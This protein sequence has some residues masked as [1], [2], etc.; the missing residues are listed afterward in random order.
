MNSIYL[1]SLILGESISIGGNG[2][3][4]SAFL[5]GENGYRKKVAAKKISNLESASKIIEEAKLQATLNHPN[6]CSVIDIRSVDSITYLIMEFLD[7]ITLKALINEK[8]QNSKTFDPEFIEKLI[9]EISSALDYAHQNR[10][11]HRD[12]TPSNIIVTK[13]NL[14]K[15][16]DFGLAS[17]ID[18]NNT[19]Y[20]KTLNGTFD[21][22]SPERIDGLKGIKDSDYFALGAIAFELVTLK[23][24]FSGDSDYKVLNSIKEK[25]IIKPLNLRSEF[26][27]IFD[28]II[29]LLEKEPS[30]RFKHKEVIEIL[31]LKKNVK[32]TKR[33]I[34]AFALLFLFVLILSQ[35]LPLIRKHSNKKVFVI[36]SNESQL[37]VAKQNVIQEK[38]NIDQCFI[39]F[40]HSI[41][42]FD[43]LYNASTRDNFFQQIH[44]GNFKNSINDILNQIEQSRDNYSQLFMACSD[45]DKNGNTQKVFNLLANHLMYV[46]ENG[47]KILDLNSGNFSDE[48]VSAAVGNALKIPYAGIVEKIELN[49][50]IYGEF[51]EGKIDFNTKNFIKIGLPSIPNHL[52]AE[53]CRDI[54]SNL[55]LAQYASGWFPSLNLKSNA[56]FI[57]YNVN[58]I[59]IEK[60]ME[61]E[62]YFSRTADSDLCIFEKN[63]VNSDSVE[64]Y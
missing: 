17:E 55:W 62:I 24:P 60:Q 63:N 32:K 48:Q 59:K 44:H 51:L 23:K 37:L 57:L 21:Y 42:Y 15:I 45:F 41:S 39:V 28:V 31:I 6:I 10:I 33:F 22:L 38:L 25:K 26:S 56:K 36:K 49:S 58:S 27:K 5:V 12:L 50:K 47:F 35:L 52:N 20:T 53:D 16:I 34:Y 54:G 19:E 13:S 64:I 9:I 30:K 2:E 7:G 11:V 4:F 46:K 8:I 43:L 1:T 18:E 3:V 14:I 61:T 40:R 29:G